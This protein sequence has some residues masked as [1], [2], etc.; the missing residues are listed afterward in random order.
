MEDKQILD[1]YWARDEA[2]IR[3]SAEKYGGYCGSIA[4]N[5]LHSRED[6][7]ECL[8]D[9]LLAAWYSIPPKRPDNLA[10]FLGRITRSKAIDRWRSQKRKKRGGDA[11]TLA[12]E[13]LEEVLPGSS[14]PERQLLQREQLLAVRRFIAALPP[15]ER[16]L[17]LCRY[18][19]FDGIDA[20]SA[21]FGFSKSKVN[22]MLHRIR[23]KL[24]TQ[25]REEGLL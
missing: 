12:L 20:L 4:Q 22:S 1:L 25:L 13:E 10:A 9:T 21:S 15:T 16:N 7:E 14:D 2:A 6:S 5:I 3:R 23:M 24:K 19:Y 11:V 17:F 18:W 8:N